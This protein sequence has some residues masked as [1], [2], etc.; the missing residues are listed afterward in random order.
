MKANP[1][2]QVLRSAARGGHR[3][4]VRLAGRGRARAAAVPAARA[5]SAS[6]TR[7]TSPPRDEYAWAFAA[8][9]ARHRRQCL[10]AR[11]L[12]GAVR[13]REIFVRIDTGVGR[14]HHDARAHRR[15]RTPS[16]ACQLADLHEFVRQAQAPEL[17]IVGSAR[18]RRQRHVRCHQLGAHR[19]RCSRPQRAGFRDRQGHRCRRR[20]G[21][22]G[23]PGPAGRRSRQA[24]YAAAR[25]CAPSTRSLRCGSS[26]GATW[27]PPPACC[28]RA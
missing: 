3:V 14:G 10:C 17:R 12:A 27:S 16:S 24:R 13:G 28:W 6:S 22:A 2:P 19:A 1:H 20:L 9:R 4:R 8:R 18:P 21:C 15:Q 26:P 25:R 5:R 23:A 7:R 11:Q